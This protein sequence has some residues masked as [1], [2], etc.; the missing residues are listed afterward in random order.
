MAPCFGIDFDADG[1]THIAWVHAEEE[2]HN[3][4]TFKALQAV[5]KAAYEQLKER[6]DA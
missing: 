6:D 3:P 1:K 5:C 2:P 4:E